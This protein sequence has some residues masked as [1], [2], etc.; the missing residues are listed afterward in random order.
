MWPYLTE[1]LLLHRSI[2]SGCLVIMHTIMSDVIVALPFPKRWQ[3]K[4]TSNAGTGGNRGLR[5]WPC[6][7]ADCR[8]G[9]MNFRKG[10]LSL[11]LPLPSIFLSFSPP[12]RPTNYALVNQLGGLGERCT[13]KLPQRG[14]A[15]SPSR[16]RI[17]CTLKLLQSHWWQSFWIF[18]VP[19]LRVGRDELATVS[20]W[21]STLSHIRSSVS[22]GVSPS[23]KEKG[24]GP[25]LPLFHINW[26]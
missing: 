6:A 25:A 12:H 7:R 21:Y 14:P 9:S 11:P 13:C 15:Q 2:G 22:N 4:I 5:L 16:K 8:G 19:H 18:W 1:C 20:P 26:K 10:V 3:R 24:A 17:W 23:P